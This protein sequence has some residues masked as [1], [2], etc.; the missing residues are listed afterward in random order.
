MRIV[1]YARRAFLLG[2]LVA[3][4]ACSS[5]NGPLVVSSATDNRPAPSPEIDAPTLAEPARYLAFL[6]SKNTNPPESEIAYFD[7]Y[8]TDMQIV[9]PED[10]QTLAAM[11]QKG[12]ETLKENGYIRTM[13]QYA[14]SLSASAGIWAATPTRL[15]GCRDLFALNLFSATGGRVNPF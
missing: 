7:I 14:D 13:R 8:L 12:L 10:K 3:L 5:G 2:F 4:A 6:S 1:V 15:S 11:T 9:C